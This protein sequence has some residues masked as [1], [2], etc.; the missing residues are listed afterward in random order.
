MTIIKPG[1]SLIAYS[2]SHFIVDFCCFYFL[3]GLLR[4]QMPDV[5]TYAIAL[6]GYNI[7]AF[8][9]QA[10]VGIFYDR[11]PRLP[12]GLIGVLLVGLALLPW[13]LIWLR[14]IIIG[15]GN[16]AF[17]IGGGVDS[18]VLAKGMTRSGIFVSTGAIGVLLGTMAGQAVI[19]SLY[20]WALLALAILLL[21]F[22]TFSPARIAWPPQAI[23]KYNTQLGLYM[24]LLLACLSIIIRSFSGVLIPKPWVND[25]AILT[26]MPAIASALG[27]ALGGIG[28]DKFGPRLVGS[29][30]LVLAAVLFAF[31]SQYALSGILGIFFFNI[32]MPITLCTIYAALPNS[33][34]LSFGLTTLALLIGNMPL[35]YMIIP[36]NIGLYLVVITSLL[37][38]LFIYLTAAKR[39]S[40][41]DN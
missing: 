38:A 8:G 19:S 33:P 27:K 37:S 2:I 20:V 30:S 3:L 1:N 28:A 21:V 9:V 39:P 6:L 11:H 16:A 29:L 32:C 18:L 24:V 36:E 17:H 31:A 26:F 22:N 23:F 4:P 13:P 40:I 14:L 41:L 34:G 5:E 10:L 25:A 12:I 35:F 7:V 15:L